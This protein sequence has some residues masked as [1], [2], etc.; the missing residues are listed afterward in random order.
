MLRLLNGGGAET[1]V[2]GGAVRN[3]LM[4][5]PASDID[6]ATTLLPA[7]VVARA[8]RA[9]IRAIPTG[10][11]HGTV[12]LMAGATPFEVTTLRQDIETDGRHAKVRF[13]R[14][15]VADA[16]RRDF[17]INALSLAADG[18]LHDVTGGVAD[19]AAR[20]VRFIGD[21]A[22]RIAEDHLRSLRFFR[23]HAAFGAGALDAAGLDAVIAARHGLA[24]LSKERVRAELLK[25]LAAPGAAEVS[26]SMS[27]AGLFG[28]L[29]GGIALPARLAALMRAGE[30]DP[31]L[32]L[33]ALAVLTV[34]DAG[35]LREK[36]RLANREH[37]RL[38]AAACVLE[39]LHGAALPP[40]G[41]DLQALLFLRGREAARDGLLL[42]RAESGGRDPDGVWRVALEAVETAKPE[43]LPFTGNDLLARGIPDGPPVGRML[44]ALQ[45]AW[46]R[47][48]FPQDPARLEQLMQEAAA[49]EGR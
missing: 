23:F 49:G 48:G 25:L 20:K 16:L 42:A 18:T 5:R 47:A 45:A 44:K 4:G 40:A 13:G 7:E 22:M 29:L 14:D 46:I 32:R 33:A 35:R 6:L 8:R 39:A 15:F 21:P 12:T 1:R 27:D 10:I 28:L 19:I 41:N 3:L 36:L 2:V 43:R 9:K 17:T 26:A 34:E 30:G 24:G 11:D 37:K 31:L 38:F